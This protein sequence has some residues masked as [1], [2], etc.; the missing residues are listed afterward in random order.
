MYTLSHF[1]LFGYTLDRRGGL[2]RTG[3]TLSIIRCE[4]AGYLPLKVQK[5]QQPG[6]RELVFS[7]WNPRIR[8][9]LVLSIGGQ[10]PFFGFS[11][12]KKENPAVPP[13]FCLG[14]RKRL[15]GGQLVALRQEGL[16][17]VLYLDF[18]GH[19]D[20]GNIKHYV[21]VFDVAGREQNIG[22]Y[23]DQ[24]L[25][26]SIVPSDEGR[27]NTGARTS[28]RGKSLWTYGIWPKNAA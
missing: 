10:E 1:L 7:V 11:D 12:V 21:L 26:A 3:I 4:L 25:V 18:E 28:R 9:R 16:D 22:L 6:K 8:E 20:F 24:L 13:G 15:E 2:R 14:L 23:E 5:I 17:R 19:D 27:F